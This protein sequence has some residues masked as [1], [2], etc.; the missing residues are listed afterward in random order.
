MS[1]QN[2]LQYRIEC[3]NCL[4]YRMGPHPM[5]RDTFL[6]CEDSKHRDK[7]SYAAEDRPELPLARRK[8]RVCGYSIQRFPLQVT[9]WVINQQR[10]AVIPSVSDRIPASA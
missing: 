10:D 5:Y 1:I 8:P 9:L 2:R 4:Q 3:Q 6:C 7:T